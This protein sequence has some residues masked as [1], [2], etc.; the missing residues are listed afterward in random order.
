[1]K[2]HCQKIEWKGEK[3]NNQ[4]IQ[5]SDAIREVHP[6][7]PYHEKAE[8]FTQKDSIYKLIVF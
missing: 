1:M 3:G 5:H 2:K 6:I 4:R 7:H 8:D